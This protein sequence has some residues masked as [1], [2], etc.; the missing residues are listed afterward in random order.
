VKS[1]VATL[2]SPK[3]TAPA[4]VA[5]HATA[6]AP[7]A[8]K[9]VAR[10]AVASVVC[11]PPAPGAGTTFDMILTFRNR[12]AAASAADRRYTLSCTVAKGPGP[13][14][15]PAEQK[16]AVGAA[17]APGATHQLT[18]RGLGPV[19]AGS[20]L[21]KASPEGGA[22]QDAKSITLT[23]PIPL[24]TPKTMIQKKDQ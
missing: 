20:Y 6:A 22:P 15:L 11:R 17:I 21:L 4:P 7:A 19:A 3:G 2:P 1:P 12:G 23:V 5:A 24:E 14:P 16:L 13:C 10:I 8:V 9:A 18:L